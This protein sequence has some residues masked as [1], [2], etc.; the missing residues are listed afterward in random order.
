[1]RPG[2]RIGRPKGVPMGRA[3]KRLWLL[4]P[5]LLAGALG[6]L[7]APGAWGEAG[8]REALRQVAAASFGT[9][10]TVAASE[11]NPVTDVKVKLGRQLFFESR[12]SRSQE[13]SCGSCHQLDRAGVDGEATSPG[14][15]GA[16]GDR[17]SPTVYNAALHIAQFW[18]GRAPDVEEQAKGP[19]LNPVE[20]AMP[21]EQS[22]VAVL[23]SI[24]GYGPMFEAAFPGED[25]PITYDNMAR[26][27]GAFERR[28]LTPSPIDRFLAGELSALSSE[29]LAGLQT[30]LDTGCTTCHNGP[31]IGG[32]LYQKLGLVHVYRT[33]DRGRAEVTGNDVDAYF[34]KVPSLR[35]VAKTAP[36]FHD[37]SVT[38]LS[39]AVGLMAWHQLGVKLSDADREAIVAFL[40]ILTGSV[41][42]ALIARPEALPGSAA[43]PGPD[44]S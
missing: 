34:F 24:P 22:V 8:S 11:T 9:L 36:Y 7:L 14:H 33:E 18:D 31:A 39:E 40:E 21:D 2:T 42:P 38:S 27:I 37:G 13:I 3:R 17:N 26:A 20:M 29:Q 25:E 35:N 16:R 19:I 5:G 43:T 12:L 4:G 28:L 30:F 6:T 15:G 44:P 10:P 41:D 1:M 23:E 32:A